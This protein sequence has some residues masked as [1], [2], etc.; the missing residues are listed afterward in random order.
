M[1]YWK[2]I[3]FGAIKD[4]P[5]K[6]DFRIGDYLTE[7]ALPKWVDLA[8]DMSPVRDQGEEPTCVAFASAAL[9]EWQEPE[10]GEMFSP[11]F[12]YDRI[13]QPTGGAYVRDALKILQKEG[14][15]SECCQPYT[16]NQKTEPCEEVK[17]IAYPNRIKDYARLYSVDDVRRCLA[18]QGPVLAALYVNQSWIDTRDGIVK[19]SG[20]V[21]GGHA[22]VICGYDNLTRLFDFKNSWGERWGD[23]G[24]GCISYTDFEKSLMDAWSSVDVIETEEGNIA[25]CWCMKS[26]ALIKK[27]TALIKRLFGVK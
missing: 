23:K 18:E 15:P 21:I 3:N 8:G 27:L 17:K 25:V 6:R 26:V 12:L 24:Y 19:G 1:T 13:A 4:I 10:I 16:P 2:N 14:I 11:R 22:I 9:K 20:A 5:D 7:K